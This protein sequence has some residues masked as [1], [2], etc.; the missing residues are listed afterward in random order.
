MGPRLS[1]VVV[2]HLERI[3]KRA[4]AVLGCI[5]LSSSLGHAASWSPD[6]KRIAYSFIGGPESLYIM[7]A[8]GGRA[9]AILVREQRDF[10]PEWAPDG[11][12]LVFTSVVEGKHVM[13]K[14]A[15]N[16]TGLTAL[17][18]PAEAAG[19]PDVSP[20]GGR[21][22][23]FTDQPR[24]RDL[25]ARDLASGRTEALTATTAFDEYSARW[26]PDGRRIVFVGSDTA[27]GSK[28]DIWI[29]ELPSRKTRNLT[30]TSQAGEFHP[31]WSY[32]GSR[33]VYIRH[34]GA[35]FDVVMRDLKSGR[36]T[37]VARGN[38]FAVLSPHFSPDDR[39]VTFT[40]TDFDEKGPGMP[41]VVKV[42]LADGTETK[43][44]QEVYLTQR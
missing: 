14:I 28:G 24:P 8:D 6:G 2:D 10:Q 44:V 23:F 37:V 18:E 32:D 29:M 4:M 33:V 31:S 30:A 9:H 5:V 41:A 39:Y 11:S 27:Q 22:L 34:E 35:A 3:M 19:D 13:M 21:V 38:G 7:D 20:D 26:A 15:P 25:Y 17:S 36:V 43:L 1:V 16:G 42:S 12:Y 40:R